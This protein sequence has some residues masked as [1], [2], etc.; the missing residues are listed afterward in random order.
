MP[1]PDDDTLSALVQKTLAPDEL[2]RVTAHLD[3]CEACQELVIAAVRGARRAVR[4]RRRRRLERDRHRRPRRARGSRITVRRR[5]TQLS[6]IETIVAR[7]RK[8]MIGASIDRYKITALLGAGGMG[9][10]YAAYDPELDRTVALKLLRPELD[11]A[12]R[13]SRDRLAREAQAMAKV[14]H[15]NVI[16]STTSARRRRR[17]VHRDGAGRRRDARGVARAAHAHV[18]RDRRRCSRA[19]ARGLAA[20]HAAGLVH[21][22]FKPDNVLVGDATARVAVTDFGLARAVGATSRRAEPRDPGRRP[23]RPDARR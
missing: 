21:R 2:E 13:R 8:P 6:P 12:R 3:T 14:S 9:V 19:R 10:V 4:P 23:A 17:G 16:R 1:C 18:A 5:H 11:E 7:R 20:A 22:D 15:P